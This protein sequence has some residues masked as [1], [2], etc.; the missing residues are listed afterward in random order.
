MKI[1]KIIIYIKVG[2]ICLFICFCLIIVVRNFENKYI[3]RIIVNEFV[4][5]EL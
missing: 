3:I 5:I 1:G 4:L 2:K